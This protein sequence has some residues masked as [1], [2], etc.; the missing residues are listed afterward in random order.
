[1]STKTTKVTL[2]W[3]NAPLTILIP[4]TPGKG[5]FSP[6]IWRDRGQAIGYASQDDS[7]TILVI[8]R[9]LVASVFELM[10]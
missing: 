7:I 10:C 4:L 6:M 2:L 8:L 5:R 3:Q 9:Y 1:M